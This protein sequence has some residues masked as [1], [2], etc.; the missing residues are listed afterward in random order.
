MIHDPEH[1]TRHK[2]P[3]GKTREHPQD[4]RVV[5][6]GSQC[7]GQRGTECVREEVHTLHEGFHRR[8]GLCVC[9][10]QARDGSEDLGDTDEDVGRG[11]DG[12][13][14]VVSGFD[15]VDGRG[16]AFGVF[17]AGACAVDEVLDD[18][19]VHHCERGD[20]ETEGD[21]GDWAEGDVEAAQEGVDGGFKQRDED[22]DGDGVEV[23]H[24]VVGDA[25]AG[26][27]VCLRDEVGGEL[28]VDDPVDWI[29]AEDLAGDQGTFEFVDE[30]VVPGGCVVG[31]IVFELP[32]GFGRVHVA[33]D[34]HDPER[35]EGVCDDGSLRGT[36]H[37][38]FAAEDDDQCSAGEH[39]Q[40]E[41]VGRPVSDKLLHVGSC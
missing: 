20:D 15:A 4:S 41:D 12:D 5:R 16:G 40:A 3:T 28:H 24:E 14:D 2:R 39:A 35:F 10:F 27:L 1:D 23:L 32:A 11:L 19:G 25:V 18:G 9:V 29:E 22:D 30:V 21:A 26:H 8:G 31:G 38:E 36:D 34:C 37:V 33:V 13:V 17:V 7:L 6:S